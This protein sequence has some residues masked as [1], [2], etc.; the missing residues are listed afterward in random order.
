MYLLIQVCT[1][2]WQ[3]VYSDP[4]FKEEWGSPLQKQRAAES[5]IGGATAPIPIVKS[6]RGANP[7]VLKLCYSL[8]PK[9]SFPSDI[10]LFK[11][12]CNSPVP[13][14]LS[15]FRSRVKVPWALDFHCTSKH[16]KSKLSSCLISSLLP[17]VSSPHPSFLSFLLLSSS[18]PSYNGHLSSGMAQTCTGSFCFIERTSLKARRWWK[19]QKKKTTAW[20]ATGC[21]G[22]VMWV[23]KT[24]SGAHSPPLS[25]L[26]SSISF[27][28]W[29]VSPLGTRGDEHQLQRFC[30]SFA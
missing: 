24:N 11:L 9:S 26:R 29:S 10:F 7:R 19:K 14:F 15:L 16:C 25:A 28:K 21:W 27:L 12:F 4:W 20:L 18:R 2:G 6:T 17:L 1:C 8:A 30:F 3:A 23:K 5:P 13:P 22:E